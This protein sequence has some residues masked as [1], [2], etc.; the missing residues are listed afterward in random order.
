MAVS[1]LYN[2]MQEDITLDASMEQRCVGA[3]VAVCRTP[4]GRLLIAPGPATA[5]PD[6]PRP[7]VHVPPPSSGCSICTAI[8]ERL[9]KDPSNDVIAVSVKWYGRPCVRG[10]ADAAMV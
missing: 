4:L 5:V 9:S 2:E 3:A 10:R 6:G 1:D 8:L 7:L